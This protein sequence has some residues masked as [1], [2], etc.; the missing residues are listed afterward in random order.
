MAAEQHSDDVEI[1]QLEPQPVAGIR[2]I[3]PVAELGEHQGDRLQALVAFLRQRGVQPAGPPFVRYH[4]FGET[5]TDFELG[6][7]V[8]EPVAGEGRIAGNTLP[9][10]AA[11]A[12]WHLGAHDRLGDAYAR[13]EAWLNEHG[14]ERSGPG[15]EVYYWIDL[16]HAGEAPLPDPSTWRTRLIQPIT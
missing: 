8:A 1:L 4:T 6:I 3:I 15:W 7:P 11:A 14:R 2:G 12:T 5:E 16:S 9:G 10:G 13:L